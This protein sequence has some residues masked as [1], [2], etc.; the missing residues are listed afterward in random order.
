MRASKLD[1]KLEEEHNPK[2][3]YNKYMATISD[4]SF[5]N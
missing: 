1:A 4:I 2:S 5:E 3:S